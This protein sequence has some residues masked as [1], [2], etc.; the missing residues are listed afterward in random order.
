[1]FSWIIFSSLV[2]PPNRYNRSN[3]LKDIAMNPLFKKVLAMGL[4]A[5]LLAGCDA[6]FTGEQVARFPMTMKDGGG[7]SVKIALGPDMNPVALNFRAEYP[8]GSQS[9]GKFNSYTAVLKLGDKQVGTGQFTVSGVGTQEAASQTP[10]AQS[11]IM[12]VQ[13]QE[14]GDYELTITPTKPLEVPLGKL[15]VELRK[16]IGA[17]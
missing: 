14:I 7:A 3:Y 4:L 12:V 6:F 9:G 2:F 1:V 15:E 16:N 13:A 8:Q 17:K 5:T 10:Y 11:Q